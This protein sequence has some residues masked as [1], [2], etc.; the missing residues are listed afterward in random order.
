MLSKRW[1]SK[2]VIFT[3]L[4]LLGFVSLPIFT[5]IKTPAQTSVQSQCTDAEI[6]KQIQLLNKGE[7]ADVKFL[8]ECKS[9]AVPALIEALDENKDE[10]FRIITIAV[11]GD[12]GTQA[13]PAVH[14]LNGLLKDKRDNI[15]IVVVYALGQIGKDGVKPL[16]F[17]LK[18]TNKHVRS[19]AANAL[20]KIGK[21]A[22]P[23]LIF[24]LKDS[25]SNIRAG[26]ADALGEIGADA[27][28]AV[29]Y[30]TT[31]LKDSDN[32]VRSASASALEKIKK[33]ELSAPSSL[34]YVTTDE[35]VHVDINRNNHVS[36]NYALG[37]G[38]TV[39]N[40]STQ[41]VGNNTGYY[42]RSNPPVMCKIPAIK[43]VLRWKCPV[44]VEVAVPVEGVTRKQENRQIQRR[45]NR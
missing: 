23:A 42:V 26:A 43:A 34:G 15:R 30:L 41:F 20:G 12:I 45:E 35:N 19:S 11:L 31:A 29:P 22:V 32:Q 24:A 25:D 37:S 36:P 27:K 38:N 8:V 2:A 17:A 14:V 44:G 9:K 7:S 4:S 33:D 6:Q 13:A 40:S 3:T 21:D 28:F 16:I 39:V 18:D 5:N 10:N 1:K